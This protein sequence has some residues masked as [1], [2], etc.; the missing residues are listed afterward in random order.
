V[1]LMKHGEATC[2]QKPVH[3]MHDFQIVPAMID[4]GI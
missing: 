3:R 1:P 2:S 4:P